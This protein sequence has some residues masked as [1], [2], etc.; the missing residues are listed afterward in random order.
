MPY[1]L[2][3]NPVVIRSLSGHSAMIEPSKPTAIVPDLVQAALAQ[4][5]VQCD[6]QGNVLING[7]PVKLSPVDAGPAKP[8][9]VDEEPAANNRMAAIKRAI[10]GLVDDGNPGH[11]NSVTGLLKVPAVSDRCGFKVSVDEIRELMGSDT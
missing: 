11:F 7:T 6:E 1:V 10:Q 3:L 2:S 9:V 5:C 8:A 4:G